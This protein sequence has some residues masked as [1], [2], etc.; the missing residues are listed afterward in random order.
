MSNLSADTSG[1]KKESR[2]LIANGISILV[3]FETQ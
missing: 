3:F 1:S 2:S